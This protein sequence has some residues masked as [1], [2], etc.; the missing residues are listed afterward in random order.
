MKSIFRT[1]L[2]ADQNRITS[3]PHTMTELKRLISLSMIHNE[4]GANS[5]LNSE[6]ISKIPY[7]ETARLRFNN[8]T[9]FKVPADKLYESLLDLDISVS[10]F[11][12]SRIS[13]LIRNNLLR[14]TN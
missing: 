12:L 4:L 10:K 8:L 6:I 7:L 11:S 5:D 2:A 14:T 3:L 1:L 9:S 13:F